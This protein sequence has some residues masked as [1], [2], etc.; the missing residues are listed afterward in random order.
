MKVMVTG[1]AGMLGRDVME[2][3]SA[4]G[5]EAVGV[6][7]AQ[8]GITDGAACMRVIAACAPDAVIHCAAWTA[9]DAAETN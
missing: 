6:D 9:V 5:Y 1:A 4:R 8:M 3:L 7:I 2:A